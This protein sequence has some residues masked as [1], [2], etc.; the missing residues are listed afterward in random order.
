MFNHIKYRSHA[1][2]VNLLLQGPCLSVVDASARV[3]VDR[4]NNRA[5]NA[6]GPRAH[7]AV[8]TSGLSP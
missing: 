8:I 2:R 4:E 5:L 1:C 7:S 6:K 3:D